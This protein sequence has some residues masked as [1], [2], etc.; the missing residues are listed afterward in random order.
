MFPN[1]FISVELV[2]LH[3]LDI[4]IL[5]GMNWLHACFASIDRRIRVVKFIILN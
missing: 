3:M 2:E 5:L 4:D 1:R